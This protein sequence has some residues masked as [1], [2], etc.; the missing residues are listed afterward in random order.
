M[1]LIDSDILHLYVAGNDLIILNS[2]DTAIELLD[3]RSTTYSS[4]WVSVISTMFCNLNP[5]ED[6]YLPWL[7]ICKSYGFIYIS[8]TR[9]LIEMGSTGWAGDGC[10][11]VWCMETLGK[12]ADGCLK[13]TFIQNIPN[14]M[15][16]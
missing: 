10:F 4:R 13:D 14:S 16:P 8:K 6:Q 12:N 15:S 2:F 7:M 5:S 3:K 9:F 11:R 1:I